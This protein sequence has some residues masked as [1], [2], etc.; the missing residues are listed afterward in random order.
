MAIKYT[1]FQAAQSTLSDAGCTSACDVRPDAPGQSLPDDLGQRLID[2]CTSEFQAADV[3]RS[4][5]F[6]PSRMTRPH[7]DA[8]A[9]AK[10]KLGL[11]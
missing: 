4:D 9:T 1:D 6:G 5:L 11:R 3:D 8:I 7:Y 2:R 10:K